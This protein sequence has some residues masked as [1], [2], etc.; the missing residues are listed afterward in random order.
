MFNLKQSSKNI[1]RG[2]WFTP[3]FIVL[4]SIALAYTLI[5]LEYQIGSS[6]WLF[7]WPS[8]FNFGTEG[9]R[10]MMSTIASS[11]MT[12]V[13]VMFSMI[14]VVLVLASSQYTPRILQNF[15]HNRLTQVVLGLFAGIFSYCL[16]VLSFIRSDDDGFFMPSLAVFFGFLMAIGGV[17]ALMFFLYHVATSIQASV[18]IATVAAE[19]NEAI[20]LLFPEVKGEAVKDY[21]SS[22]WEIVQADQNWNPVLSNKS[23]YVQ[24]VN[25]EA[26]TKLARDKQ[27]IVLM[28]HGV[29]DFIIANTPLVSISLKEAPDQDLIRALQ[30]SFYIINHRSIKKDVAFG[31]RQIEDM[32]LKALSPG[33][34]ETTTAVVCLDYLTLIL[35]RLIVRPNPSRFRCEDGELRVITKGP[36]FESLL[37][38]SFDQ[39]RYIA[40]GDVTILLKMADS[41]RILA[42]L[43]ENPF[44]LKAICNQVQWI[45]EVVKRTIE[46]IYDRNLLEAQLI[47]TCDMLN[48]K[49]TDRSRQH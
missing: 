13:G 25:F 28:E 47:L 49:Q 1:Y 44:F 35:S 5:E 32:A 20:D 30:T 9:A 24:R 22:S 19:T 43:T 6:Y 2:F 38:E 16:I 7:R 21:E 17:F 29:G 46:S 14:L 18:I 3:S 45:S 8:L 27:I 12:V 36:N 48:S 26:I 31:I 15:I 42:S 37:S 4:S 39:I 33:V 11:M 41:F 40:K 10:I 34:T 23:G